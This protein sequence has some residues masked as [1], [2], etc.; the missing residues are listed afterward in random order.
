MYILMYVW[1]YFLLSINKFIIICIYTFINKHT[2][3]ISRL[4]KTQEVKD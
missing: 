3:N 4:A 1:I 2:Y